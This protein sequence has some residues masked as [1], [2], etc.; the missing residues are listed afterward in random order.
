MIEFDLPVYYTCEYKTK[1][2]T[3]HL[4]GANYFRNIHYHLKN[5]I[6]QYYHQL[7][8]KA[9]LELSMERIEGCYATSY[10]YYYKN[11]NTDATNVISQIEKFALDGLIEANILENDSVKFNSVSYGWVAKKDKDN[12]RVTIRIKR[13]ENV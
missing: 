2:N 6:K 5:K 8:L 3:T 7:V 1:K 13:I 9:V 10:I 4:V 12:P 11:S